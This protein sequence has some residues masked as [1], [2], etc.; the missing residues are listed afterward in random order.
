MHL[1]DGKAVKGDWHTENY[2]CHAKLQRY[3]L[4]VC[5]Y[6]VPGIFLEQGGGLQNR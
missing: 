4:S 2:F 3:K 5:V 6:P 1:L